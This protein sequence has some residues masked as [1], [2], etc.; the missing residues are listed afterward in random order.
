MNKLLI[1]FFLVFSNIIHAQEQI[2]PKTRPL[3][4]EGP[5]KVLVSLYIID[6]ENIDN[7]KQS[8]T[9]DFIVRLRWKDPR[10]ADVKRSIPIKSVWN[11]NTLI[12]NLRG[13]DETRFPEVVTILDSGLVEYKQRYYAN[14]GNSLDFSDFPF[15]KQTLTISFVAF[16]FSPNEVEF[17]PE[18]E[19]KT[20]KFSISDWKI[21]SI[22]FE[23]SEFQVNLFGNNAKKLVRPKI[24]YKFSSERFIQYYRWKI[25]APL[26]V[27]L[28][29]SWAVFWIDPSQVGAQ[30]GV[31]GTSILTL[32]A[33]LLRLESFLPPVS[34]LTRLDHFVFTSLI[35]VFVAYLEALVSTTFALKG[36]HK[37]ALKLDFV[38][39]ILY[40]V[41]FLIIYLVF[42]ID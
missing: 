13:D 28:F 19:G 4:K 5:T 27:I 3:A 22:G 10:L 2:F 30:I 6:I 17:I 18:F 20:E 25:L 9:A 33:F 8:F 7:K 23:V 35:L 40:P 16:G 15:D 42:W 14:L 36:N 1:A 26:M 34:Y 21:E 11:P 37:L 24:E 12:Y 38:F 41:L 39:R 31:A 29:L 32:I